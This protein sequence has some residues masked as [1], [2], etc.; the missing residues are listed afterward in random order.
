MLCVIPTRLFLP[1][2]LAISLCGCGDGRPE[3]VPLS[4][5][6][7]IDGEPLTH[8]FI[9]VMPENAR[10]AQ[11]PLDSEGR[12]QLSTFDEQ[13]G[14]VPGTHKVAVIAVESLSAVEQKW[15]APKKY[16]DPDESGL[17]ITVPEDSSEPVTL[18]L[19]WDGAQPFV[20]KFE[21]E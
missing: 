6:V 7:L 19:S 9:Q 21:A 10:A 8:G 5:V 3:R 13:D 1:V 12:F 14:V 2:L 11:S 17:T 18:N 4:G 20:E 15:H 16:M